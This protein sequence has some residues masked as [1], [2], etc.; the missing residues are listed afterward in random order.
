MF[1]R[2]F[3][4]LHYERGY[5]TSL[6]ILPSHFE[7]YHAL[8]VGWFN[9][10]QRDGDLFAGL[11]TASVFDAVDKCAKSVDVSVTCHSVCVTCHRVE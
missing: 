10:W 4:I 1:F 2:L 7:Y 5:L 8:H 6:W 9:F 3:F 11:D